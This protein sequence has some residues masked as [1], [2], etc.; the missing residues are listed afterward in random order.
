MECLTTLRASACIENIRPILA[1]PAALRDGRGCT[2][3]LVS[4]GK[5]GYRVVRLCVCHQ[6]ANAKIE[7][8]FAVNVVRNR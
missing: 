5:L 2:R 7:A 8:H 1:S 3:R 4:D 6:P